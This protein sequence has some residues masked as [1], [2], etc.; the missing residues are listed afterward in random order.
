[1]VPYTATDLTIFVERG[2][3]LFHIYLQ[4]WGKNDLVICAAG[5]EKSPE[6][7][8]I[9]KKGTMLWMKANQLM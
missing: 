1:M 8:I 2:Q 3:T 9:V 7:H 6:R 5:S 4:T